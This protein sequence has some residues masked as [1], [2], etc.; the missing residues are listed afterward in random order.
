MSEFRL[1]GQYPT[2]LFND[3][4]GSEKAQSES[5]FFSGGKK[6]IEDFWQV[7]FRDPNAVILHLEFDLFLRPVFM[8]VYPYHDLPPLLRRLNRIEKEIDQQL[9]DQVFISKDDDRRVWK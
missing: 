8:K 9:L 1:G 3:D 2:M 4:P 6:G 5:L 7:I